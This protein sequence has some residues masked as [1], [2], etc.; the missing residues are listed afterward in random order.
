VD[1]VLHYIIRGYF[2]RNSLQW[3]GYVLQIEMNSKLDEAKWIR[4]RRQKEVY[5]LLT[6]AWPLASIFCFLG[7]W[8]QEF[9][10]YF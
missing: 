8:C 3:W 1:D 2:L 5:C 9:L 6:C 10:R 7:E 4:R